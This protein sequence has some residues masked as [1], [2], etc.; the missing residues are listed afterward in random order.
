MGSSRP[1]GKASVST[2]MK[3]AMANASNP[4]KGRRSARFSAAVGKGAS[5]SGSFMGMRSVSEGVQT[6]PRVVRCM[7]GKNRLRFRTYRTW[8]SAMGEGSN[9]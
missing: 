2:V 1:A 5:S 6:V 4:P 8:M 9:G 3:P 7:L